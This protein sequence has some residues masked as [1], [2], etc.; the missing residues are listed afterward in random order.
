MHSLY[1]WLGKQDF[2]KIP[3]FVSGVIKSIELMINS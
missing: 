3:L 1:T 2:S